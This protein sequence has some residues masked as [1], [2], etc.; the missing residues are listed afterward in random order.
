M[1]SSYY[2]YQASVRDD[3]GRKTTTK[4]LV[5]ISVNDPIDYVKYKA[6]TTFRCPKHS[7]KGI[8]LIRSV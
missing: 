6:A 8:K 7:V 2:I 4:I 5:P 3:Y 1:I